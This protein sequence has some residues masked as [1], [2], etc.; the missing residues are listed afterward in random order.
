MKV[1]FRRIHLYL[2]LAAGLVILL[3]CLTGAILVFEKDLQMAMNKKRYYVETGAGKLSVDSLVKKVTQS[4]PGAKVNGIKLYSE[5]DRSAEISVAFPPKKEGKKQQQK[6]AAQESKPIN[7][8]PQPPQRQPGFTIFINP[9]TGKVLEKYSYRETGF[10]QVFAMH[11]WLLG[12]EGSVGKYIVGVS[13]FIFL[14]ILI[15]GIV[16]WWPKTKRILQKRLKVKWNANWKRVNH[17]LHMVFGFYSAIFLFIFAFTGLAWSFEWFNKGIYAVTSSPIKAPAPPKSV[18]HASSKH[19]SFDTALTIAKTIYTGVEFYTISMP[20]D[21]TEAVNITALGKD[22]AHESATDAIYLDQYSGALLGKLAYK[23]RSL[24]ARV[25]STFKPVHTGSIW[26]LPSKIV[27]FIVCLAGVSF[28]ITGTI[29]WW[30][31]T[32]KK[33]KNRIMPVAQE[34]EELAG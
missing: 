2:S 16:L 31:R 7:A 12:G 32:R 22:A 23:D 21:S 33:K 27:A 1:F 25:R 9:Y 11:R 14:F 13:T 18:Y 19:I 29:M 30:N 15:T 24:G 17:D 6:G 8:N 34:V 10:Y 28:P 4:F 20:K 5:R 3:C 26:G